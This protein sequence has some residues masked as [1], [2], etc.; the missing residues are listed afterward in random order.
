MTQ[1]AAKQGSGQAGGNGPTRDGVC[2]K[3]EPHRPLRR[4]VAD[5]VGRLAAWLCERLIGA[6]CRGADLAGDRARRNAGRARIAAAIYVQTSSDL[7][8][9]SSE[10]RF[11]YAGAID[12]DD[13]RRTS[14]RPGGRCTARQPHH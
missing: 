14:K 7:P 11:S 12:L 1:V 3:P 5:S 8:A 2:A 4:A 9:P 10:T 13:F 6:V